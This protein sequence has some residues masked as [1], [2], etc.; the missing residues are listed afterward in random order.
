MYFCR[1][2]MLR[3]KVRG[4]SSPEKPFLSQ[5]RNEEGFGDSRLTC[6]A[7]FR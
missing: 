4:I 1:S 3:N 2:D 6:L 5:L 7:A